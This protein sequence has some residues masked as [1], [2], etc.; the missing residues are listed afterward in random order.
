MQLKNDLEGIGLQCVVEVEPRNGERETKFRA[1][2]NSSPL[3]QGLRQR[4]ANPGDDRTALLHQNM[5][6]LL[7][8]ID[9][10][11]I[12]CVRGI[13]NKSTQLWS[14]LW[15]QHWEYGCLKEVLVSPGVES[16]KA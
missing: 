11:E 7:D 16:V 14:S 10:K 8:R 3:Q 4:C 15:Y 2:R 1:S 6:V 13:A 9:L 5:Q 12:E